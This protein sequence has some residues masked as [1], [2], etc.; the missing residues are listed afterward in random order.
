MVKEAMTRP[1]KL[2][3]DKIKKVKNAIVKTGA[4]RKT[5]AA[6]VGISE[7]QFFKWLRDGR[8]DLERNDKPTIY[9]E[10]AKAIEEADAVIAARMAEVVIQAGF[11]GTWQAAAWWLER[12][13][14]ETFAKRDWVT[15]SVDDKS[16]KI[17]INYTLAD[18]IDATNE[19]G[20]SGDQD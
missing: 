8:R 7:G 9:A 4:D 13:H 5:C 20:D 6:L 2:N 3:K 17:T 12:R 11:N 10:F 16:E 14:P 1:L 18:A 19:G 15:H